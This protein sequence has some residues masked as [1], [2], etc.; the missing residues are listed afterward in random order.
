MCINKYLIILIAFSLSAAQLQHEFV[1]YTN[2]ADAT[3]FNN[4]H[5]IVPRNGDIFSDTIHVVYHSSDSIYYVYTT[6]QGQT[7]QTPVAVYAGV[8]PALDVD[9][10][11]F[12]HLA[13]QYFDTNNNNYEIYYDCLDDWCPPLNVSET[14]TNSTLPD[15]V[16]DSTGVVHLTWTDADQIYY[17]TCQN[18]VLGDTFRLSGYGSVQATYS[19]PSTSIFIPDHRVY[20]VWECYDIECYS[21]YQIH[22]RYKEDDTWS[23][24]TTWTSY[25]AMRHPSVDFS[26]GT[27]S[28]Y[29]E[30]SLCYE[31]STS[32]NM[33]ATFFGGNGGGYAT[34]GY[35]TYPVI[36]TVGN[37]WSYLFWQEDSSGYD[38]ICYHL[39]YCFSGWSS[40][41]LRTILNIQEPVRFP[42]TCGAYLVWTQGNSPPYS[43][44][45]ADFG[46]PIGIREDH[47]LR[48]ISILARPNPFSQMTEIRYKMADKGSYALGATLEFKIYNSTGQLVKSFSVQSSVGGHQLSVKWFGEDDI[49]NELPAGIYLC[50][51]KDENGEYLE[52]V[53]KID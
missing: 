37:T 19:H 28:I 53:V 22:Y 16:A 26:H 44:Y 14:P 43:V 38:D 6:D 29:E 32:G 30:L 35:S 31:D 7:W 51:I 40:G 50:C 10:F 23:S 15:L 25:L 49:G 5:K 27:E 47:Q 1:A 42:N 45:F 46:Y 48:Q 39:Y 12:R 8:Y 4:S 36:S 21:P 13:W 52:K 17:R 34:Q 2:S 33:E 18:G 3:A 24:T 41:S 9:I 11:G 20:V